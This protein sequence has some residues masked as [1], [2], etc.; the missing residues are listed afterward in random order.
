MLPMTTV[1]VL[2]YVTPTLQFLSGILILGESF[3]SNRLIG[4]AGIWIGLAIF[5]F[6]L[7]RQTE[8]HN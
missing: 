1:G 7:L 6:S 8:K 3:D 2:F 5:T 4:F